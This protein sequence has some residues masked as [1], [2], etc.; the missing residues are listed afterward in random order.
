MPV[1]AMRAFRLAAKLP[2][3]EFAKRLEVSTETYRA[4]DSSR[5]QP[6]SEILDKAKALA[7]RGSRDQPLGLPALAKIL[8]VSVYRLRDAA[9]DGRLAVTYDNHIVFGR[10]VP[11][12]TQAAGEAYRAA[13]Y[14]RRARWT[15]RPE[16][17]PVLPT[18][19][20]DY[21]RQLVQLRRRLGLSQANLAERVG[22]ASKAVVYQWES[23]KRTPSRVF[24]RRVQKLDW[25]VL[26]SAESYVRG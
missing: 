16:A 15:P 6:P 24:W 13:Y 4:W 2:Q 18:V 25:A 21:D 5:R 20:P 3:A 26:R 14:G 10:P 8:G 17:P 11:N 23:R 22:A 1:S 12:A 7:A 9:R 19:P